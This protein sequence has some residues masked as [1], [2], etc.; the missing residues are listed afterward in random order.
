MRRILGEAR[1]GSKVELIRQALASAPDLA[2]LTEV[3]RLWGNPSAASPQYLNTLW[4]EATAAKVVLECGSGLTTLVLAELEARAGVTY[5]SLEHDAF[6]VRAN[7]RRLRLILGR[8][9]VHYAPLVEHPYGRWYDAPVPL[10]SPLLVVCDGP[11]K[12]LS[13]RGAVLAAIGMPEG[14]T[15]L[16]DDTDRQSEQAILARWRTE[17]PVTVDDNGLYAVVRH[18]AS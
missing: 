1:F 3:R 4:H 2:A 8:S 13:D 6:W 10:G 9:N 7:R 15:V 17:Y 14:L 12:T 18:S 5:T 16:L 11:P